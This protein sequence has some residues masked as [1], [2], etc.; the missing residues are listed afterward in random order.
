[1]DSKGLDHVTLVKRVKK[2]SFTTSVPID[3]P[4]HT[5]QEIDLSN[6]VVKLTDGSGNQSRKPGLNESSIQKEA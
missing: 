1:V 5:T 4:M 3:V 6:T 2:K